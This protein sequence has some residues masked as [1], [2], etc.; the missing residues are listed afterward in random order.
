MLLSRNPEIE[1]ESSQNRCRS[2]K[3]GSGEVLNGSR[4]CVSLLLRRSACARRRR[5]RAKAPSQRHPEDGIEEILGL[6][7]IVN[8][9]GALFSLDSIWPRVASELCTRVVAQKNRLCAQSAPK[10]A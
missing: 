2:W 5:R 3:P 10:P 8:V 1:T 4:G 7:A 6:I 9:T